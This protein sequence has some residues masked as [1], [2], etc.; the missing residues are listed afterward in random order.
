[1]KKNRIG[2]PYIMKKDPHAFD[3][4]GVSSDKVPEA[5]RRYQERLKKLEEAQ[6]AAKKNKKK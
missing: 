2:I 5:V 3:K 6:A 1:M 4:K